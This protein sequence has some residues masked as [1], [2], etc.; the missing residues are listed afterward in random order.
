M[1]RFRNAFQSLN[2]F[3]LRKDRTILFHC[4]VHCCLLPVQT[5]ETAYALNDL[6]TATSMFSYVNAQSQ[7]HTKMAKAI[8]VCRM[9]IFFFFLSLLV[10]REQEFYKH[11]NMAALGMITNK[12]ADFIFTFLFSQQPED[13]ISSVSLQHLLWI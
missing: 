6:F 8:R 10:T 12:N 13:L 2:P 9:P 4:C 11:A 5:K 7:I 3:F 1:C